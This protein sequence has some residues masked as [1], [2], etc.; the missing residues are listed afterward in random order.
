M[1]PTGSG[2]LIN[3]A[4]MST[5]CFEI[6]SPPDRPVESH[7]HSHSWH[8]PA[9]RATTQHS[10]SVQPQTQAATGGS[11][12]LRGEDRAPAVPS[13][14]AFAGNANGNNTNSPSA[15]PSVGGVSRIAHH[16]TVSVSDVTL[17]G[18]EEDQVSGRQAVAATDSIGERE[19]QSSSSDEEGS[20]DSGDGRRVETGK[21]PEDAAPVDQP[22]AT[23][24]PPEASLTAPMTSSQEDPPADPTSTSTATV[25][26]SCPVREDA[27]DVDAS[28]SAHDQRS[29][30]DGGMKDAPQLDVGGS[31]DIMEQIQTPEGEEQPNGIQ[32][33]MSTR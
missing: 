6:L 29:S 26:S 8:A 31:L 5:S 22:T 27:A 19:R 1:R 11:R 2:D 20:S 15:S 17:P 10:S 30:G 14:H 23:S 3:A 28:S 24:S 9:G 21:G 13:E 16:Q 18:D 25:E 4:G 12:Q 33:G 32:I 7:G